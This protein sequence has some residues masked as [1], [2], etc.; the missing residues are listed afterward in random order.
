MQNEVN[1]I[2]NQSQFKPLLH[3]SGLFTYSNSVSS[4]YIQNDLYK[5]TSK[6]ASNDVYLSH[7]N[8]S[9][10]N[11][12]PVL[13]NMTLNTPF[14]FINS[15]RALTEIEFYEYQERLRRE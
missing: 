13:T 1:Q 3:N 6:L 8:S 5:S 15:G 12:V 14:D 4:P 10:Y 9:C 11:T 7:L 2:H